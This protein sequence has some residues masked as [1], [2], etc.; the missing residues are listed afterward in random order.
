MTNANRKRTGHC[1]D[2]TT[3]AAYLEGSSTIGFY[4]QYIP[5]L[6][7]LMLAAPTRVKLIRL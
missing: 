4:H 5:V 7:V 3:L 2:G 6:Q 1:L